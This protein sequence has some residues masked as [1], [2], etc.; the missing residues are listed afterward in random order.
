MPTYTFYQYSSIKLP[1][2]R[3]SSSCNLLVFLSLFRLCGYHGCCWA[4]L[5]H[6]VILYQTQVQSYQ[7]VV[8]VHVLPGNDQRNGAVINYIIGS[9]AVV[10]V[11]LKT[12]LL[13]WMAL[14]SCRLTA[15]IID[16]LVGIGNLL[17]PFLRVVGWMNF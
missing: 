2:F 11:N 1:I 17:N 14:S 12:V 7:N 10:D 4:Y 8:L 6:L 13:V 9:S 16:A 3:S 5:D 15:S